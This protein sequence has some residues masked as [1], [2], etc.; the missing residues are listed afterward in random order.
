MELTH[1]HHVRRQDVSLPRPPQM[2]P[3]DA[4]LTA[5]ADRRQLGLFDSRYH[6]TQQCARPRG[7]SPL[8]ASGSLWWTERQSD[9]AGLVLRQQ[10]LGRMRCSLPV[11][12]LAQLAGPRLCAQG[13]QWPVGGVP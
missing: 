5:I 11:D 13:G 4:Q 6:S 1:T 12:L 2:R 8:A 3:L 9:R 10:A 7:G